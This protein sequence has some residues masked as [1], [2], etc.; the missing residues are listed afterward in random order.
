MFKRKQDYFFLFS[1]VF[2]VFFS[3]YF[4][5]DQ[6][7]NRNLNLYLDLMHETLSDMITDEEDRASFEKFY[8][9][10][11]R[12]VENDSLS[13]DDIKLFAENIIDLK[14]EKEQINQKDIET[15]FSKNPKKIDV[16]IL[17]AQ[18]P[19][20]HIDVDWISLANDFR[21]SRKESDSV[22]V[23][24]KMHANIE[25]Q[26]SIQE[27]LSLALRENSIQ[28]A[29]YY[30]KKKAE[31]DK[32]EKISKHRFHHMEE[33]LLKEIEKIKSDNFKIKLKL[34][35]IDS[36]KYIIALEREKLIPRLEMVDSTIIE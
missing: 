1:L 20:K 19:Q 15:I 23:L 13:S 3:G 7:Q 35:S 18:M 27:E 10:F 6:I 4:I 12:N 24:K 29:K 34:N 9:E 32:I 21:K 28:A 26:I 36:L 5:F 33:D 30:E 17:V 31:L 22:L 2:I 8:D 16:E 25:A 14:Q 11:I